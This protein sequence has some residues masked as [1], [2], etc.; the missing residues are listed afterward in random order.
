MPNGR[1]EFGL[2]ST[3]P[4]PCKT[5]FGSTV[6][7]SR[8]RASDGAKVVY[9]R[10]GSFASDVSPRPIDAYQISHPNG[11][12]LGTLFISPCQNRVSGKAPRGFNL[13][14]GTISPIREACEQSQPSN[15]SRD[16][17]ICMMARQVLSLPLTD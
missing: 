1:G 4:I 3:N 17:F 7:L 13:F 15:F 8:L 5:V 9:R 12:K 11:N 14:G 2:V 10:L 16:L 6:Y